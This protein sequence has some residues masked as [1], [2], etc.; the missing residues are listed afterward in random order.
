[1]T[2]GYGLEAW[3]KLNHDYNPMTSNTAKGYLKKILA[4]KAV[5]SI[6]DITDKMTEIEDLIKRYEEHKGHILQPE[7][8][9]QK[10]YDILPENIAEK[11]KIEDK[12][13]TASFDDVR[14]RIVNL[15]LIS[16]TGKAGMDL[17]AVTAAAD[18]DVVYVVWWR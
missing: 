14:K 16:S 17:D 7:I 8:Q 6:S 18:V 13:G 3:R 10:L 5:K 2:E 9:L 1:M 15:V 11:I 4:M 12:D